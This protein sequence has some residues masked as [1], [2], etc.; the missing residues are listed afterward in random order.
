VAGPR[1]HDARPP[2]PVL[3]SGE[4]VDDTPPPLPLGTPLLLI[5]PPAGL[6]TPAVFKALDLATRS[7]AD[8][9]ALAAGL[10]S[11]R[12]ASRAL[13]VNDLEPPAFALMPTLERAKARLAASGFDAAFMSGS[14]STL[15]GVGPA[16]RPAW[17]D[18]PEYRDWFV[19]RS[20]LI[21]R[22]PGGWYEGPKA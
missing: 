5:K 15:V 2:P 7:A 8:P 9:R 18:D 13:C 4:I 22:A 11:A 19:A 6:P 3:A 21:A 1:S 10:A 14:G 12:A 16:P 17:L 20:A